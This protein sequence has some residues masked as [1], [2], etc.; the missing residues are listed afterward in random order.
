MTTVEPGLGAAQ[1][2]MATLLAMTRAPAP[3]P[4]RS[5]APFALGPTTAT[6]PDFS[7]ALAG[8][9][10]LG[11]GI[12]S[13]TGSVA[14]APTYS[15]AALRTASGPTGASIVTSAARHLGVPYVW[16]GED[17]SGF[18]CSGLVQ[19]VFGE[20]GIDLPRVSRDQ[21]RAGVPVSLDD[22]RAGDLVF[23]GRPVDH[24]GIYAGSGKMVVAPHR[25][26]HVRIQDVDMDAITAA[27][28]VLPGS[29]RFA[30][31]VSPAGYRPVAV[32]GD[33]STRLPEAALPHLDAI[34][35]AADEF[36]VDPRLVAAV[37]WTESNFRPA[38]TSPAGAQGIMQL[39]PATAAGLGV[40][41][42]DPAD[43]LRGGAR[44]LAIQL[45]RFGSLELAL[46]A[47]NA[48]PGAVRKYD[49]I[50]PYAETQAYVQKVLGRLEDLS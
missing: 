46:A 43:N 47:Y 17:P 10:G 3:A 12:G 14:P 5:T 9:M 23:F 28:R 38:A 1:A 19:Y 20:Q 13:L 36:G 34:R 8:A 37:A 15:T 24:V 25:G 40:D 32:A 50:P 16:G 44:Y 45:E 6:E 31:A 30:G 48:G 27:R 18:D 39:M 21:A 35:A 26:A 33:W 29:A 7:M 41:P 2:R 49:G 11:N 4:A 22:L 42:H